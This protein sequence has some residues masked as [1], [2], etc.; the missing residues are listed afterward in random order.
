M[1]EVKG[2]P[3]A[4]VRGPQDEG[5]A[6]PHWWSMTQEM[7]GGELFSARC[8]LALGWENLAR[9][10]RILGCLDLMLIQPLL[11]LPCPKGEK[12]NIKTCRRVSIWFQILR[13]T[14]ELSTK[15]NLHS[16]TLQFKTIH[17]KYHKESERINHTIYVC[18]HVWCGVFMWEGGYLWHIYTKVIAPNTRA[19]YL[20]LF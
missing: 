6:S 10:L 4:V 1:R 9:C 8:L 7:V 14:Q 13:H 18:V 11:S 3:R 12:Q 15:W 20:Y 16:I 5:A 19:I 17:Q 2:I